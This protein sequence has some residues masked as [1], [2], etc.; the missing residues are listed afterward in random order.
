MGIGVYFHISKSEWLWIVTAIFLM[1][2]SEIFNSAIEK[3]VDKAS[4]EQSKLA[5]RSKDMAAAG[6]LMTALLSLTI[7]I[8][9]FYPY[10]AKVF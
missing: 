3:V 7:G 5:K 9:I 4:P 10:F 1:Y 6:V 2:I 8:I